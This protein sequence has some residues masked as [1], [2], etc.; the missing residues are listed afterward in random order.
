M[1]LDVLPIQLNSIERL[2]CVKLFGV[3]IDSKLSFSEHVEH[4]LTV[5]NQILCLF[6]QLRK[7]GLSDKCISVSLL[8][9]TQLS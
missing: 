9:M 4:L 5:Y 2:E 8:F 7:Q 3:F 1:Q 6:S